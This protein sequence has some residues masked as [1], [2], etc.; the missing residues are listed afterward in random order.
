MSSLQL[1][2]F[3]LQFHQLFIEAFDFFFCVGNKRLQFIDLHFRLKESLLQAR[4]SNMFHVKANEFIFK[5]LKVAF[6][7]SSTHTFTQRFLKYIEIKF[8][9]DNLT[10]GYLLLVLHEDSVIFAYH[11]VSFLEK[12][13]H[14]LV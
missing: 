5:L 3:V 6:I 7:V 1:L 14:L 8:C 11:L 2:L 9:H 10:I 12:N 4:F 13:F